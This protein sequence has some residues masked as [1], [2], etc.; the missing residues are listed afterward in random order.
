MRAVL[1]VVVLVATSCGLF[2][3]SGPTRDDDGVVVESG[4]LRAFDLLLGDCFNDPGSGEVEVVL[5]VPCVEPHDFEVYHVF[6][7]DDGPYP[8]PAVIEDE[9]IE[10]CLAEFEPFVGV[11]FDVS[12]LDMSAIFPTRQSWDELDDR[13]VLCSVTAVDGEPRAG[14]A[15]GSND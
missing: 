8:G 4:T 5:V 12:V 1:L 14:S 7:L 9:W 15:R 11:S 6:M 13:V 3:D 10:G 2:S